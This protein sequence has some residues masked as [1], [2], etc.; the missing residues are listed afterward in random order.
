MDTG[1]QIVLGSQ[2][3]W[4]RQLLAAS[5]LDFICAAADIDEKAVTVAGEAERESSDASLLTRAIAIAKAEALRAEFTAALLITSGWL[6]G[7]L[8]M[9]AFMINQVW[10]RA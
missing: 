3:K 7:W 9:A 1:L 8:A 10:K 4:R 5:G 6:V 2:S